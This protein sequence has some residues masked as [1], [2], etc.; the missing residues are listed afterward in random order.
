MYFLSLTVWL[1]GAMLKSCPVK[2]FSLSSGLESPCQ[3]TG[4]AL[5]AAIRL[6]TAPLL[7][8]VSLW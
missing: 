6:R 7:L 8:V 3:E 4:L 5:L 1:C 2:G